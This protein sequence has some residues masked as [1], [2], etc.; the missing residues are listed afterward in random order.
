MAPR[1]VLKEPSKETVSY[2]L[3]NI[4]AFAAFLT[5]LIKHLRRSSLR[6]IYPDVQFKKDYSSSQWRRH[7]SSYQLPKS[8]NKQ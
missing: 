4:W 7:G 8:G 5:V 3:E 6:K 2:L 1:K